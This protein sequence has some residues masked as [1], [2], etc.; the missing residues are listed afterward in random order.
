MKI[1]HVSQCHWY[2][3]CH[4]AS[5]NP[6]PSAEGASYRLIRWWFQPSLSIRCFQE[7]DHRQ[8]AGAR[9]VLIP[10]TWWKRRTSCAFSSRWWC[11]PGPACRRRKRKAAR[12]RKKRGISWKTSS[13]CPPFHS[14]AAR[15]STGIA[16]EMW[17]L[18][19]RMRYHAARCA[20][21]SVRSTF[22]SA[23][24]VHDTLRK[25]F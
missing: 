2:L 9:A 12:R 20:L 8:T 5:L 16:S 1:S 18:T 7:E 3:N 13:G 19:E 10:P 24:L 6:P 14:T 22:I 17:V 11:L 25:A 15:S 4:R 21:A 23:H